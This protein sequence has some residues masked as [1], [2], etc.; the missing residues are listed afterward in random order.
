MP[1]MPRFW[2]SL[3]HQ[4][5]CRLLFPIWLLGL[6]L[7]SRFSRHRLIRVGRL[8][9]CGPAT[10]I[11]LCKDSVERLASLDVGIHGRLTAGQPMWVFGDCERGERFGPPWIVFVSAGYAA[12]QTDGVI[13]WLVYVAF[14]MAA[15]PCPSFNREEQRRAL[16]KHQD[17]LAQTKAW[18]EQ[19]A[20]PAE[21]IGCFS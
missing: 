17:V 6:K 19:H 21:L 12:R 13:A 5:Y 16:L 18:L 4:L 14:Y 2:P 10:F 20:F 3:L 9:I 15:F 8:T 11:G 7:G 1:D